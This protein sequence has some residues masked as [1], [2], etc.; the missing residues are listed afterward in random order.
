MVKFPSLTTLWD[1]TRSVIIRFPIQFLISIFAV[2]IWWFAIRSTAEQETQN[3]YKLLA[4]SNL[5]FCLTLAA[6]LFSETKRLSASKRWMINAMIIVF[7]IVLFYV[8]SP[9]WYVR[10]IYRFALLILAGHLLVSFAPYSRTKQRRAFWEYNKLL[11]LRFLTAVLYSA[12]LFLGLVIA[13]ASTGE[14][15]NLTIDSKIYFSLFAFIAA[16]FNTLFFLA[17][18]PT[19]LSSFEQESI[20]PKGLKV[21]TQYVLIPLLTIYLLI[22]IIYEIKILIDQQ[23]PEGMVSILIL[24]YAVFGILSYLL[25]YPIRNQKGNEWMKVF[26]KAFFIMMIPLLVLLIIAV[27]VRVADYAITEPRYFLILLSIW[28]SGITFYFLI[29]RSPNIQTIPISLCILALFSTFGPQSAS[30]IAERS[31]LARYKNL[32][33]EADS[34][35]EKAAI[36]N[37]MVAN[38][39][40][41]SLQPLTDIDLTA[42]QQ[43]VKQQKDSTF[44]SLS[45]D[46]S[47]LENTNNQVNP[48]T[49]PLVYEVKNK[50]RDTAY[51]ILKVRPQLFNSSYDFINMELADKVVNISG[52]SSMID[53][54]SY[55][56]VD[57]FFN[58]YDRIRLEYLNKEENIKI[59]LGETDSV[60]VNLSPF[61]ESLR[62]RV[63]SSDYNS[64]KMNGNNIGIPDSLLTIETESKNYRLT[65][66]FKNLNIPQTNLNTDESNSNTTFNGTLLI[67]EIDLQIQEPR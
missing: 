4:L 65:L 11:F 43:Q 23:L 45:E 42:V 66:I 14:L 37:Y 9:Q 6:D 1:S 30:S 41:A 20:Y 33:S 7:C 39:G 36:I 64:L 34:E 61:Y 56:K 12:T 57:E 19:T 51:S 26:S 5:S 18:V 67:K 31:Q 49:E 62:K 29:A 58:D 55:S 59:S 2:I 13:L 17:G 10:D 27:W 63:V 28:L 50:L 48:S 53:F 40:L 24:G 60:I 8:L 15:F 54:Q 21:F 52:Y 35:K 38:Y 46:K 47:K 44:N 3:L 32:G 25:T 22:L 16:G